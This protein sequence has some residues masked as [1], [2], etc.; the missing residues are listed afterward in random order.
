MK[1]ESGLTALV[2]GASSGIGLEIA[3][4][5]A[6]RKID[7]ILVSRSK[8]KLESLAQ[9]LGKKYGIRAY[10]IPSDLSSCGEAERLYQAC[11]KKKLAVDILVNNAGVGLFG[12]ANEQELERTTAMINLNVV[13]LTTLSILFSEAMKKKGRG[14]IL[15]V[16]SLVGH[17]PVPFFAAYSAT[18]AYVKSFSVSHRAELK[19]FGISVTNLEP[20]F[21][22][23]NFDKAADATHDK[24]A[25]ISA[26]SGMTASAVAKIGVKAMFRRRP[27]VVAGVHN[28]FATKII[29]LLP[30]KL[31]ATLTHGMI[32][33]I[34]G[35]K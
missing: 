8:K 9:D 13:A 26:A 17:M 18:K 29:Y 1:I 22:R 14:Y 24:Y 16:G 12:L 27:T 21:V 30:K 5:L 31:I 4:E 2:T 11:A 15:N 6:S 33:R 34:L 28:W 32:K 23:T 10:V 25:A 7:L 35:R 19:P 3:N 20:G